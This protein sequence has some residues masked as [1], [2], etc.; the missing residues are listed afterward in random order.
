[1]TTIRR[2]LTLWYTVALTV[3][4]V[5]FGTLVYLE[6]RQSSLRELDQQLLLEADLADRW[7]AGSYSVLGQIVTTDGARP[8]LDPGISAYLEAVRDPLIV[9]DTTGAVLAL[10]ELA[11]G[12][13]ASGIQRLSAVLDSLRL[14]KA[15]GTLDLGPPVGPVRYLAMRV[16]D[17]GPHVGGIL[18]ATSVRR[19]ALGP[20]DLLRSMLL[21]APVILVGAVLVGYWLAGTSLRPVQ[22][23]MDEVEAIS[24]GRSLHRRLAVPMSGD[25]MARL[26][27]T[28][29]GMLARLEQSFASLHRFTADASHELKTPLMVLRAGVERA[30]THPGIPSEI[31]QS[32]DE[33]LAQINQM[34][35]M[36]ENL[37][38]LARAD[39]GRA[40]L[41]VEESDLRELLGDVAETAG[42]LGESAGITVTSEHP[43]VPVPLPVDRHRIREMLLNLVT[44]AIKY[45]AQGGTV[46]LALTQE[47]DA[48]VFT[49]RDT[50]IGIAPGDL[51]HIFERFWRA[52]PARSRTGDRPGTG[53][54]LS[55][56][57]WIAEAHGGSIT[58]QSRPGRG[59]VFRVRLPREAAD[60]PAAEEG[61]ANPLVTELS[62]SG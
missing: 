54:G 6:R 50:G 18:V 43:A 46:S 27:L 9:V 41:A 11:R 58:V 52:D 20:T 24:D 25:E 61:A 28:V 7:L 60:R 33:T 1:M 44:N 49:V 47:D 26:A 48:A 53:L 10:S 38:T 32:L 57:K 30:L 3:T 5:A 16:Q 29:N 42:M 23:I 55:I 40:P 37:L 21:I 34:S 4:V 13:P 2:R 36:V 15:S 22:G 51:P 39:E 8:A 17:A 59:S 12:L 62:S 14:P 19:A 56:T 45:T 35:E 31:L